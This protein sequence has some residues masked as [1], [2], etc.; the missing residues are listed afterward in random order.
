MAGQMASQVGQQVGQIAQGMAQSVQGLAQG[1]TQLPQQIMQGVQGIVRVGHQGRPTRADQGREEKA[2]ADKA[3]DADERKRKDAEADEKRAEEQR[4]QRRRRRTTEGAQPGRA[5]DGGPRPRAAARTGAPAARADPP[6]AVTALDQRAVGEA[7]PALDA[8]RVEEA[9]VVAD[10][11]E[12]APVG[13]Q[14]RLQLADADQVEVVGRLVEQQQLRRGFGVEH[15]RPASPAA[16]RRPTAPPRAGGCGR[17]ETGTA[18]TDACAGCGVRLGANA[19][20]LSA[21][22]RSGSSRSSRCDR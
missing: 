3:D 2:D 4:E 15:A 19:A 8:D 21:T 5:A 14:R 20:R 13:V 22:V 10:H 18:P 11:H 7:Q 9:L 6:A 1:L 17:R 16:V 12:G